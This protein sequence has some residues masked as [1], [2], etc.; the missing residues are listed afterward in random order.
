MTA[1]CNEPAWYP[2]TISASVIEKI[3][4]YNSR[5][6]VAEI[7]K[8]TAESA[9]LCYYPYARRLLQMSSR[10]YDHENYERYISLV[11]RYQAWFESTSIGMREDDLEYFQG[12]LDRLLEA[13]RHMQRHICDEHNDI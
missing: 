4:S 7:L 1:I 11:A 9:P 10:E 6:T 12:E 2:T 3:R 8:S 5:S 13:Q